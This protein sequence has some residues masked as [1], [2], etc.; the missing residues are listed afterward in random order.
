MSI[1][2]AIPARLAST[3]LPRKVLLDLGGKPV[4][5]HV[6]ERA[7]QMRLASR[8]VILADSEELANT[9]QNFGAEVIL[10]PPEC[11]SGTARLAS[12]LEKLPGNFFLNVQ[13]D[14]PCIEPT[15][16]D[17]L[18]TRWHDTQCEL[19]TAVSRIHDTTRL[20]NPN[21]VKVVR[22][23]S[24]QALYF[25]RSPVPYRRG[26]S[27]EKWLDDNSTPYWAHIGVYGYTRKTLASY[28]ALPPTRLEV[29]ESLEQLRFIEHG[30]IFQTVETNYHPI[31]ID[32]AEDLEN[33]RKLFGNHPQ[34][35][36]PR[37]HGKT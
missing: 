8:V 2:V 1:I 4:V 30:K 26:L 25:S 5:Q 36:H 29:I 17:A 22:G 31:A 33:A 21:V 11:P 28:P 32:T 24:G 19:V 18:A 12:A 9:A 35:H 13:G 37:E 7:S 14:E 27:M 34:Q 10:T 6:W 15:L 23:E 3:R 20:Q 16:L